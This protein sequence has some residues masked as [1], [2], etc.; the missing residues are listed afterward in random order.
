MMAYERG[1]SD[2][3]LSVN[4]APVFRIDGSLHDVDAPVLEPKDTEAYVRAITADIYMQR[5]AEVGAADFAYPFGDLCRWRV[6][7][8][9]QRGFFQLC[10]RLIPSKILTF[11]QLGL[12]HAKITELMYLPRGLILVT[13]PTGS[14]KSTTLAS[15]IDYINT[16]R[17]AHII[18]IEDPIE[19]YHPHKTGI[20]TQR[21]LGTDTPS[22]AM[23]I[24]HGLRQD[25]DVILVGEMRDL[26]TISAAITAAETGH[27]VFATL[28]T[29]TAPGTI[30]R[31]IDAFPTDQQEMIRS[32]LSVSLQAV[33]CQTL[34][35]RAR[36]TG[37]VAAFEIMIATDAVRA[38]IKENKIMS[39]VSAIQTSG[40][41]GM[42]TLEQGL[43]Q[44]YQRGLITYEAGL[45][46][47]AR[48]DEFEKLVSG[49]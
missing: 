10:L 39:L 33:I 6:S 17:D 23:A 32:Q 1:A 41:L 18:T 34:L 40:K 24:R 43:F 49:T 29:N 27:L 15:M 38:M 35:P 28:H 44:L 2:V 14:G 36:G 13:G 11:E 3:H 21:E 25:P 37:R 47:A 8:F 16:E 42:Q 19:F 12:T 5:I 4:R 7:A 20:V 46:K 22:F 31:I 48:K 9:K 26:E 45:Q 30:N